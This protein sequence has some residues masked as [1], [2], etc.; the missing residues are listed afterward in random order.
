MTRQQDLPLYSNPRLWI[1]LLM[2]S[3]ATIVALKLSGAI[4]STTGLILMCGAAGLM[5]PLYRSKLVLMRARNAV[6]MAV[7]NYTLGMMAAAAA[8]LLGLGI[9]ITLHRN[10]ELTPYVRLTLALLPALPI[11]GMIAVMARYLRDESDEYLRHRM[12]MASLGGLAAV[13]GIGS[14]WGFL[15]TFELVPHARGW[16]S[17]PIWALGVGL[18]RLWLHARD[19][20]PGE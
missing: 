10:Y 9:A 14:F 19:A 7:A 8:Y 11:F 20:R 3:I 18:T 6:S 5:I 15:E 16:W 4:D 13:L 12:I 1:G 17:V 2:G